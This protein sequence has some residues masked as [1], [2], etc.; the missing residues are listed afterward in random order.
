MERRASEVALLYAGRPDPRIVE[1]AGAST[2]TGTGEPK[3]MAR[4]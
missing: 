2:G 4:R 3:A 1:P